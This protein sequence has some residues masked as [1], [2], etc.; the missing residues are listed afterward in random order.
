LPIDELSESLITSSKDWFNP[1]PPPPVDPP[2]DGEL[3]WEI[4]I[5][6]A[7]LTGSGFKNAFGL[8]FG[9]LC[10]LGLC[11]LIILIFS[12]LGSS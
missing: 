3:D 2:P 5:V 10:M 6:G 11:C 9:G 4:G 8:T 7:L 12:F 1:P